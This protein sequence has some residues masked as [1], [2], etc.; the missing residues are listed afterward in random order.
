M[1]EYEKYRYT[2]EDYSSIRQMEPLGYVT[3]DRNHGERFLA[4]HH[5]NLT[6]W[7]LLTAADFVLQLTMSLA[8]KKVMP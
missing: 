8:M 3:P 4:Q 5:G 1:T 2:S 6:Y 7:T